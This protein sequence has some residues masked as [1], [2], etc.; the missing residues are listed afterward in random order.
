MGVRALVKSATAPVRGA[1]RRRSLAPAARA[2]IAADRGSLPEDP[3]PEA[4]IM[5][6]LDWLKTAQDHSASA[7]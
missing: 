3:G 4:A 6:G 2:Q 7:D 1:L 5:A